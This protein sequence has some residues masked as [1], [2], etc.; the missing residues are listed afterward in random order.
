MQELH[1]KY[2][3]AVIYSGSIEDYA[4]SQIQTLIDNPVFA[5]S[6]VRIMP[7]V[8]P[9]QIGPIGFTATVGSSIMP[10]IVGIDI[11]CGMTAAR[12]KAGKPEF[13]RLDSVIR[14]TVPSGFQIRKAAHRFG[15][16]FDYDRLLCAR[17]VNR[18]KAERSVGT[19]GGG[20]HFIELDMDRAGGLWAV[21]HSGSRHLGKE[22]SEYYL[23]E[24][25]KYWKS[26]NIKIPHELTPLEGELMEAY[27]H[28]TIIV[29]EFAALNREAIL[30]ELCR[31]MKWKI[32]ES[33][34]CI[35]N[36]I[37]ISGTEKLIRKG[38]ISAKDGEKVIIPINMRDGVIIGT[39][40][41]NPDWNESAPHGAG[42]IMKRS[43]VKQN[44]TVSAFKKEMRGIYS[45]RIGAETLDEA[46]FAYRGLDEIRT[47]VS[48]TVSVEDVLNPVYNFKAG[49]ED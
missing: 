12:L 1:G 18:D 36:Y 47:A 40:K 14:D 19:L 38:A 34:S 39:G 30:D 3:S 15:C 4:L 28:D 26:R 16:D 35:H 29:Q 8:H 31:G 43:E 27:I 7:D 25:Q 5:G 41:G 45:S 44:Y 48:D 2:T 17:H 23:N 37:D 6:K 24:G 11:G 10:G 33:R 20:N 21:I 9:G 32:L 22:V 49:S 13:Q 42:R 46:P